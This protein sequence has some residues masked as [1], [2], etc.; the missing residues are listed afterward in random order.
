M[1]TDHKDSTPVAVSLSPKITSPTLAQGSRPAA[2]APLPEAALTLLALQVLQPGAELLHQG[3]DP[4]AL[5]ETETMGL[6][7]R[8]AQSGVCVLLLPCKGLMNKL[9]FHVPKQI[10]YQY[11]SESESENYT[12][13]GPI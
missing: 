7:T 12:C 4:G 2:P 13:V 11:L 5:R 3:L 10:H 6:T 8:H 9:I 1:P